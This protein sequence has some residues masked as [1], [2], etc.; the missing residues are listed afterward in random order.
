MNTENVKRKRNFKETVAILMRDKR[1][2]SFLSTLYSL[3]ASVVV[4]GALFKIQHWPGAGFMLSAGLITEA[5]IFFIYA[6]EPNDDDNDQHNH[7]PGKVSQDGTEVLL[8]AG[9]SREIIA[10]VG[11]STLSKFDKML[12]EAAI[13]PDV[14]FK[15]GEGMRKLGETTENMN[16]MVDVSAASIKYMET[17]RKIDESLEKTA[18]SYEFVVSN[19]T[20]K[21]VFKYKSIANSLSNVETGAREFEQQ[22]S[23]LNK[24]LSSLNAVYKQQ[25]KGADDFLKDQAESAAESK[26]YREQVKEL[27]KNLVA[28]NQLY[29]NML[30]AV[31]T[32]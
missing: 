2:K 26:I 28:L 19:V 12:E 23:A 15:F 11:I 31:K 3:G 22:M 16:S 14:F 5:L 20:A 6:F 24:N 17:I 32:K 1:F 9:E 27:N 8:P 13:T 30:S 21:T 4:L 25:K 10:G 29:S 18:K 7:T